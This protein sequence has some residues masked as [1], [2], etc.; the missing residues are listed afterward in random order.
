MSEVSKAITTQPLSDSLALLPEKLRL[1]KTGVVIF[2]AIA[3]FLAH[4]LAIRTLIRNQRRRRRLLIQNVSRYSRFALKRLRISVETSGIEPTG[5]N[6][7][8]VSNHLSYVDLMVIAAVM[9]S[10]FVTSIDMGEVFFLGTMAEI[11]GSVF[12]ERRHRE[13]IEAD[14]QQLASRL[15]DGFDVVLFPEGTSS[16]GESVL[17]F[18]RS[19][20]AAAIRTGKKIRPLTLSYPK[21]DGED[22]NRDNRDSVCWYGKMSFLPHFLRLLACR[23]IEA[24]VRFHPPVEP[25]AGESKYELARRVHRVVAES[26]G[27]I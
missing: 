12:I 22:F 23:S 6:F 11:G 9:P 18:K 14:I 8:V 3:V 27:G 10:V 21:I 13:R 2:P 20:F 5:E 24:E 19:L 15:E 25:L 17:P 26:F 16:S 1:V 7:L 4:G